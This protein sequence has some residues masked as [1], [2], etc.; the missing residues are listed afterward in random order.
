VPVFQGDRVLL[1]ADYGAAE[2]AGGV[3]DHQPALRGHP[4]QLPPPRFSRREH[5]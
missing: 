3:L 4:P 5:V 2:L 1:A